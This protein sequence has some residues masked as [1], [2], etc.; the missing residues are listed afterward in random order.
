MPVNNDKIKMSKPSKQ[1]K[2][3]CVLVVW[4]E[5]K[6]NKYTESILKV[7]LFLEINYGTLKLRTV[8]T[9]WSLIFN[10]R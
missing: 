1:A 7:R 5:C 8:F 9:L 6:S 2:S 10:F 4:N 3:T